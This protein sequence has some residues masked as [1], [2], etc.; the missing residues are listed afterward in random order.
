MLVVH[1]FLSAAI[2]T[3]VPSEIVVWVLV[4]ILGDTI[5]SEEP[6]HTDITIK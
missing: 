3:T 5:V 6:N 4:M 1:G 2:H